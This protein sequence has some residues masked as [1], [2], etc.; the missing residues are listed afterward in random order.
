MFVPSP[1]HAIQTLKAKLTFCP[2]TLGVF[3]TLEGKQ[4]MGYNN[5]IIDFFHPLFNY[6]YYY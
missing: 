2:P 1:L 6:I 5:N 4:L 3:Q